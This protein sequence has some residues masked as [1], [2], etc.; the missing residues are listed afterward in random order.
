[1]DQQKLLE[2]INKLIKTQERDELL[3]QKA[4]EAIEKKKQ[5]MHNREN[6]MNKR[7]ESLK[8]LLLKLDSCSGQVFL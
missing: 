8:E 5:I 2:R 6:R 1:M 7:S 3:Q 4:K